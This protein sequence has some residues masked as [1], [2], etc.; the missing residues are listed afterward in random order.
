MSN[1]HE[2][3]PQD[4]LSAYSG[5]KKRRKRYRYAR[6]AGHG[7]LV[8]I[9]YAAFILGVSMILASFIILMANDVFAFIS[10][11]TTAV[12]EV[13]EDDDFGDI[14]Q[15]LGD[16][17]II[18][19]PWLFKLYLSVAKS[20]VEF[21]AGSYEL[22]A[23][24]DYPALAR[25]LRNAP[26]TARETVRVT[27]P[28]GYTTAQ[29]IDLLE[30]KKVASAEDLYEVVRS[31]EF[32]HKSVKDL[33]KGED[34]RLEGYLFPDTYEFYVNDTPENVIGK[35]ISNFES[36]FDEDLIAFADSRGMT[37][38]EIVIIASMI[39]REA[40]RADERDIVSSVI[41]NRL[42]NPDD[43]PYLQID[44]TVAYIVGQAP[45]PEDLEIDSPYNTYKVSGLPPTAICNPGLAAIESALYPEETGYYYYVARDNG[46]HIFSKTLKEHEQAIASLKDND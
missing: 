42:N 17:G 11:E 40:Q 39:E 32:R 24:W 38:R 31:Y 25:V 30:E 7:C 4:Q 20:D 19:Y 35:L 2:Y 21:P 33:P 14:A 41:Y 9:M 15:K 5:T 3:Q 44:A 34:T 8:S 6:E 28:E 23:Q 27:I 26:S 46:S 43:F 10:P 1:D 18:K 36:K 16:T 37:M 22:N 45:T 13:K 12:V 29:I